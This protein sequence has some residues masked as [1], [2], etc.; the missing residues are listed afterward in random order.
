[1]FRACVCLQSP[2]WGGCGLTLSPL[3]EDGAPAGVQG[4]PGRPKP[5]LVTGVFA[6]VCSAAG[7]NGR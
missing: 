6:I 5:Q 2:R 7:A 3:F 1:M 4:R